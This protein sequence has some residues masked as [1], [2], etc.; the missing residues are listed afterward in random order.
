[1]NQP[2]EE[3]L[4]VCADVEES[5]VIVRIKCHHGLPGTFEVLFFT[6]EQARFFA[7]TINKNAD[8]VERGQTV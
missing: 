8:T 1:M 5:R 2:N 7:K 6:P 3:S 4:E